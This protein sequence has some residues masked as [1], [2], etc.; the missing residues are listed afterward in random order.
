MF[1]P[2]LGF[3]LTEKT[4]KEP[5][6]TKEHEGWLVVYDID[7][8][9][10]LSSDKELYEYVQEII[11]HLSLNWEVKDLAMAIAL[12]IGVKEFPKRENIPERIVAEK[13]AK[14]FNEEPEQIQKLKRRYD[15]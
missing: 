3:Y 11:E 7:E 9:L 15:A 1:K 6:I 2:R 13:L 12:Y 8:F 10:S 4:P 5:P 14:A